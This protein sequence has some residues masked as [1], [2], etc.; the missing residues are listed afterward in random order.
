MRGGGGWGGGENMQDIYILAMKHVFVC[1]TCNAYTLAGYHITAIYLCVVTPLG[2]S[3]ICFT[4]VLIPFSD[5]SRSACK[6]WRS[7]T[8][9]NLS[10]TKM[11]TKATPCNAKDFNLPSPQNLKTVFIHND[12]CYRRLG[13]STVSEKT[14]Y[15][16]SG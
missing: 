12:C 4:L 2:C 15:I 8:L 16:H 7:L 5:C 9:Q 1:K 3:Q 6:E 11:V 13:T 10:Q 14:V